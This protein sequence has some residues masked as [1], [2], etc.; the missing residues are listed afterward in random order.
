[1]SEKVVVSRDEIDR[2]VLM[3]ADHEAN[4]HDHHED[5]ESDV[6]VIDREPDQ[7]EDTK[8]RAASGAL[9]V[10][11]DHSDCL[12]LGHFYASSATPTTDRPRKRTSAPAL[13]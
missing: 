8:H 9:L 12:L 13:Q 3:R 1:M 4:H 5:P 6:P 11:D 7:D 10:L 2:L